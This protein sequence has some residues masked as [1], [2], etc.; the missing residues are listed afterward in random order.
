[1]TTC[2][3]FCFYSQFAD[4]KAINV[5]SNIFVRGVGPIFLDNVGCRGNET[6]LND[7]P[8]NGVG[9]HNCGHSEDAGV[10]CPQGAVGTW[11]LYAI[12]KH[13]FMIV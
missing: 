4:A 11:F 6:N 10:M 8:H 2:S 9:V 3:L 5:G 12:K 13:L 7:C 1:M